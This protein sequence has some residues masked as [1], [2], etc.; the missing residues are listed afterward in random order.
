MKSGII[1]TLCTF[2]RE[3]FSTPEVNFSSLYTH[4]GWVW[5][6]NLVMAFW[7]LAHSIQLDILPST[8][9]EVWEQ[10]VLL[11]SSDSSECLLAGPYDNHEAT[12]IALPTTVL[13]QTK[14]IGF[15]KRNNQVNVSLDRWS[16][17]WKIIEKIAWNVNG[18]VIINP[19]LWQSSGK[20]WIL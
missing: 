15:I 7:V 16:G 14:Q 6:V 8:E 5:T 18:E 3:M 9:H 2:R 4:R 12:L 17:A 11:F 1:K 10:S 19:G 13:V 20:L